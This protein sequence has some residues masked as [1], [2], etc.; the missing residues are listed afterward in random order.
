[1]RNTQET[2]APAAETRPVP[3]VRPTDRGAPAVPTQFVGAAP[4]RD[5]GS[6]A[7]RLPHTPAVEPAPPVSRRY[8]QPVTLCRG[9]LGPDGSLADA[10]A[11]LL[12]KFD[13]DARARFDRRFAR[14]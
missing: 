6:R 13:V 9:A 1:M 10:V 5:R 4:D 14:G 7:T 12:R 2:V 3:P 8:L 11:W